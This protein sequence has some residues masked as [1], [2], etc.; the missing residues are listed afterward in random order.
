VDRQWLVQ[1]TNRE[2]VEYLSRGAS[3]SSALAQILINR[4]LKTPGEVADFFSCSAESL[5]EPLDL[6]GMEEALDAIEQAR[7]EGTRVM[8]HG[9][10]D[11]DGLTATAIMSE[12][13]RGIGLDVTPFIPN[14]FEH[15]YGFNPPAVEAAAHAGTGLIVTVDCGI[16]SFE[17]ADLAS[18]KGIRVLITDHHEPVSANGGFQLPRAVAIVN[19]KLANTEI[20][21]LAGSGVALKFAQALASLADSVPLVEENRAIVSGGIGPVFSGR[22]AGIR[23]LLEVAGL[24]KRQPRAGILSFTVV[25][26]LN[27]AGRVA[28]PSEALELLMTTSDARAGEIAASLNE[29]NLERQRIEEQVLSEALRMIDE[30]GGEVPSALVLAGEGWHEGVVGIV[31]S[32]I[33]ERFNR[34]AVILSSSNGVASGSARSIPQ[35]DIHD[36]LARCSEHLGRFGGHRQAAG[37][38]LAVE[39]M[40]G[41]EKALCRAVEDS[42]D[43]FTP[44]LKIDAAID[45]R[46]VTFRLAE[47]LRRLEPF[48]YGNP[49]PVLGARSLDIMDARIVGNNHLKLRLRAGTTVL[50]AIGFDMGGLMDM[51]E[52]TVRVDAA[53]SASINEWE[54][55]RTIQMNLKALRPSSE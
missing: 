39:N 10:Y 31:A 6:G 38:S 16:T 13:L 52:E 32:R 51:L 54:G 40:K 28:D 30:L 43:D 8:V 9:D 41:F 19:P 2:Y 20:S 26:R 14:R 1:K 4:G 11:A 29:R 42:V 25:P 47:E 37:L 36:G 3:V 24:A 33:V 49:E 45:L 22:R 27:A 17:A 35:F 15:G 18:S 44:T 50:D 12:S 21:I 23:A 46:E 53:F 55:G 5:S 34:P 7:R 48:G